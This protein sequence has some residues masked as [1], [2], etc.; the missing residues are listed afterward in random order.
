MTRRTQPARRDVPEDDIVSADPIPDLDTLDDLSR[1]ELQR[2]AKAR[3]LPATGKK[4]DLVAAIR[5]HHADTESTQK[6]GSGSEIGQTAQADAIVP[7]VSDSSLPKEEQLEEDTAEEDHENDMT[8][9]DLSTMKRSDL[10]RIAKELGLTATGKNSDLIARIINAKKDKREE[11]PVSNPTAMVAEYTDVTESSNPLIEGKSIIPRDD[12]VMEQEA[13]IPSHHVALNATSNQTISSEPSILFCAVGRQKFARR[14][15]GDAGGQVV[16][17][18]AVVYLLD[19]RSGKEHPL[20]LPVKVE[21]GRLPE[22]M[23]DNVVCRNCLDRNRS[24]GLFHMKKRAEGSISE[25]KQVSDAMDSSEP[26]RKQTLEL[27]HEFM[28]IMKGTTDPSDEVEMDQSGNETS[29]ENHTVRDRT[30]ELESD[31]SLESAEGNDSTLEEV[32]TSQ[33][34]KAVSAESPAPTDDGAV[35]SSLMSSV[36]PTPDPAA[37]AAVASPAVTTG[38]ELAAHIHSIATS[39]RKQRAPIKPSPAALL[40]QRREKVTAR[41]AVTPRAQLARSN[42]AR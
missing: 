21:V 40:V 25:E 16:L 2:M 15:D 27:D 19:P 36:L 30:P 41:S 31:S 37:F 22:G 34:D 39:V 9:D 7:P 18:T 35:K 29:V 20:R 12:D 13:S 1:P 8:E 42:L 17:R 38:N 32:E 11:S 28:E 6:K 4:T 26:Q 3:G 24:M 23:V 5:R 10:Q 14:T 33:P